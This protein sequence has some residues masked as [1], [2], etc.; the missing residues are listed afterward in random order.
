MDNKSGWVEKRQHERI[1]AT[2]KVDFHV[3]H[4]DE[5]KKLLENERYRNTTAEQLPELSQKSNLYKAVTKDISLGGLALVSQEILSKGM[6]LEVNLQLPS[7]HTTL[8][9][10]AEVMHVET[11]EE[12]GK[13]LFTAGM[14]TL[15][16]SKD[17][18]QHIA[19][20]LIKQK[21][22]PS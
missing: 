21:K 6:L 17:D 20:Y 18:V 13:T 4:S 19:D 15:A 22:E 11:F 2:L 9:F 1:V 12:M 8:K 5:A 3:I 14:K 7:Y 16:I 10:I